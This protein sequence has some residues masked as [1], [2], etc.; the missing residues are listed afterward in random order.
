MGKWIVGESMDPLWAD[1][2]YF[3]APGYLHSNK[4]ILWLSLR[5]SDIIVNPVSY[6]IIIDISKFYHFLKLPITI[7][8]VRFYHFS[9]F[10]QL[11]LKKCYLIIRRGVNTSNLRES[12][13]IYRIKILQGNYPGVYT[14]HNLKSQYFSNRRLTLR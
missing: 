6:V 7:L 1:F 11:T 4:G 12:R 5:Y 3:L 9:I 8:V 14:H 2:V 13:R 10:F